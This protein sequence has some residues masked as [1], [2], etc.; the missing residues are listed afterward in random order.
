MRFWLKCILFLS[1]YTP[2]FLIIGI[3]Y[4]SINYSLTNSIYVLL[5]LVALSIISNCI[6]FYY[7][8]FHKNFTSKT[9]TIKGS[10]NRTSDS[11]N[12]IMTYI[13]GFLG[14][15]FGLADLVT[16][17]ILMFVIFVVVIRSNLILINPILNLVGYKFYGVDVSDRGN[18]IVITKKDLKVDDKIEIRLINNGVYLGG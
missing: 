17:F 9:V 6:M 2:L 15:Q 14:L 4:Y 3:R 12:Y 16:L 18:I 7:I 8:Y 13:V 1:S 10:V 11:L 5:I